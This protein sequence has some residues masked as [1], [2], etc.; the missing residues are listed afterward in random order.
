MNKQKWSVT[1]AVVLCSGGMFAFSGLLV[2][3]LANSAV[4]AKYS[5][6][7][8]VNAKASPAEDAIPVLKVEAAVPVSTVNDDLLLEQMTEE[9]IQQIYDY[10][11]LPGDPHSSGRNMTEAETNRWLVLE[12]QYVYDGVRPQK[13]LPLQAGQGEVY[14]DIKNNTYHQPEHTWTDEEMLQMID[15]YYRLN[16]VAS[17]RNIT[18]P[19]VAVPDKFSQAEVQARAAESVRKLFDADVSKLQ[20]NVMLIQP[21]YNFGRPSYWTVHSAP[22]KSR[23]LRGQ[24]Q[25]YW[26]YDVRIDPDTGVVVDT[27][28]FN[29]V[30]KRTP[31]D[32]ATAA[33]VKKDDS[34]IKEATRIVKDKQGE[35]RKIVKAYLTDTEKNNKRGMVA[36][37][38]LLEDGSKYNAEL[39][40]PGKQLRCLIYEPADKAK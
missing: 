30:I 6:A 26:Q 1:M 16:L 22:Y 39:R 8:Q 32:A 14:F 27:T 33:A 5:T 12:D 9:E 29:S 19:P 18:A 17:K 10:M 40:Y 25:E 38:V 11:E 15:W 36:V 37:D 2:P 20:T 28:A 34:W 23:T 21:D 7:T 13:P 3:S 35:K 4:I 31:I 24:G